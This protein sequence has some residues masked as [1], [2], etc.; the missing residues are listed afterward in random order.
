MVPRFYSPY[1]LYAG[2]KQASK[3]AYKRVVYHL[4]QCPPIREHKILLLPLSFPSNVPNP[5]VFHVF[6]S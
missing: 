1:G 6:K 2:L 5:Y 4:E 3:H